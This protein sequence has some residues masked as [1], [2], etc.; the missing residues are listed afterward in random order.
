MPYYNKPPQSGLLAH[1]KE[2]ARNTSLPILLY[3]V[4]GRTVVGLSADSIADLARVPNIVG[5]KEASADSGFAREVCDRTPSNFL[6]T[7]G[8]DGAYLDVF[9]AGGRGVISVLSHIIPKEMK[10]LSQRVIK[11]DAGSHKEFAKY[12]KLVE[13]L[14]AEANPIPVKAA[15]K[16][17]GHIESDEVRLPLISISDGLRRDLHNELRVL[18]VLK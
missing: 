1:Y 4:P 7:G 15:M 17:M 3:N 13:I 18:G 10:K 6:V 8:D 11:G 12:A 9:S 16:M 5:V 2:V 14:F